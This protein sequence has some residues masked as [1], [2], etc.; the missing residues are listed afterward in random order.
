MK[1]MKVLVAL[2]VM[3]G[4]AMPVIAEDRLS[5]SG[6]MQVRGFYYD[7][8][9]ESDEFDDNGA[10]NDQRLRIAGKIAV[11]EGVSVNFR[12]DATESD[13]DSS[14]AVAWGGSTSSAYQY[15]Q[16]RADIQFDK[17]YLQFEKNGFT[18][19]AGQLYFG[20]FG[21]TRKM[22]DVVGAGFVGK[23]N[24]FTVAHVKRLDENGGNDSFAPR[25]A[26]SLRSNADGDVSLTAAK[27]DFKGD[28]FSLTPM[29]AYNNDANW[30]DYDLL[31][32]GLAGTFDLGALKLKGEINYFDGE[33]SSAL[34]VVVADYDLEGLQMYLDLSGAA[35][36]NVRLGGMFFY[37]AGQDDAYQATQMNFDGRVNWTFADYHPESYGYWSGDFVAEFSDIYDPNGSGAGVIAAQLYSDVKAS[38]NL[39]FKFA[40]M[41]FQAE[42]DSVSDYDGYTFNAGLAYTVAKNTTFTTHL[43]YLDSTDDDDNYDDSALQ[44]I[45]GL[46]VKF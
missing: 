6:S 33:S 2:L 21:H 41:Y 23:Y 17:A 44:V 46:V 29:I 43:N 30:S 10:W 14:D 25:G 19:Q 13:E 1:M 38:D 12:L 37:A 35:S 24:G 22:L 11:A 31:G 9:L 3:V 39:A 8:D 36:D 32:L 28:G 20:G 18:L 34:D 7:A 27:Y 40:A 42:D 16:R 4:M 26:A 15:A 5:L 45:S